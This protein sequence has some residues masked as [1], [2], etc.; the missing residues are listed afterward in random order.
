MPSPVRGSSQGR[1][2]LFF[3]VEKKQCSSEGQEQD[4][5]EGKK[6]DNGHDRGVSIEEDI[7]KIE[8]G[9]QDKSEKCTEEDVFT[10]SI[11]A[12]EKIFHVTPQ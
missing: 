2:G 11:E 6:E 8:I 1:A 7:Y 10:I 4:H 9:E 3:L 12:A 5:K